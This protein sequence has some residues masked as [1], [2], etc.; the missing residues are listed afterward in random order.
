M[1]KICG[2]VFLQLATNLEF[3]CHVLQPGQIPRAHWI[4]SSTLCAGQF[5]TAC[6]KKRNRALHSGMWW[7]SEQRG[8][9]HACQLSL[10]CVSSVVAGAIWWVFPSRSQ[11]GA[12]CLLSAVNEVTRKTPSPGEKQGYEQTCYCISGCNALSPA[13]AV[14]P[15]LM[16]EPLQNNGLSLWSSCYSQ[17]QKQCLSLWQSSVSAS[18]LS[19]GTGAGSEIPQEC[20]GSEWA[21]FIAASAFNNSPQWTSLPD[22]SSVHILQQG[23]KNEDFFSENKVISV[24]L[25]QKGKLLIW[26]KHHLFAQLSLHV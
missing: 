26:W 14:P 7:T 23:G 18:V 15:A 10:L 13:T 9:L 3:R 20:A 6:W 11:R 8:K 16:V 17:C 24:P 5:Y 1:P 21:N 25:K 12:V 4:D 2:G 22:V 19:P